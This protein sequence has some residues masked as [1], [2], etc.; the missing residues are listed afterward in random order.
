[1]SKVDDQF[2]A[3]MD[4][5]IK[6]AVLSEREA[7]AKLAEEWKCEIVLDDDTGV[8]TDVDGYE[9]AERIRA[10]NVKA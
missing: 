7:C 4:K 10:R 5:L 8:T 2:S 1:M 3:V 6:D 9:I